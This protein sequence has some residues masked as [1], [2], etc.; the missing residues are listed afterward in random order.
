MISTDTQAKSNLRKLDFNNIQ[1]KT[2]NYK[3]NQ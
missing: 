1:D 3:I 2:N